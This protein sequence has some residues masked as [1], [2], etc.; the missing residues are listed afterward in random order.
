[1]YLGKFRRKSQALEG[2]DNLIEKT[3]IF[4]KVLKISLSKNFIKIF[5][6]S[7]VPGTRWVVALGQIS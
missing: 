3:V 7:L 2:R 5:S 1:M 6:P 4:T